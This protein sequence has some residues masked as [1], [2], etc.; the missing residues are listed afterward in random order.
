VGQLQ[1]L[2]LL[3]QMLLLGSSRGRAAPVLK[4][5]RPLLHSNAALSCTCHRLLPTVCRLPKRLQLRGLPN[6]KRL[7]RQPRVRCTGEAPAQPVTAIAA[8][9]FACYWQQ[10]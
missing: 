7:Q 6:P 5:V 4:P 1:W 9:S 2:A 8:G 3:A 10:C